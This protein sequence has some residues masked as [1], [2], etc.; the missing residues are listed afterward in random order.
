MNH[1][2]HYGVLDKKI[3][4]GIV[5]GDMVQEPFNWEKVFE[6]RL[7]VFLVDLEKAKRLREIQKTKERE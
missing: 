4:V 3:I 7:T 6:K 2:T 1:P 5:Q